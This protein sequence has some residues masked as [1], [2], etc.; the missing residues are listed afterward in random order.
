VPIALTTATYA[1]P[2]GPLSLV[3]GPEGPLAVGFPGRSGRLH[4]QVRVRGAAPDIRVQEGACTRTA[5]AL[6]AYFAGQLKRYR[7]PS[8]L[9][10]WFGL[11]EAQ[12]A[13]T[14]EMC[15][16]PFG[17]TRTYGDIARAT[18]LHPRIVGQMVGAN[19]L[20]ILVPCHRVV[21]ARGA[22]VGYGGGHTRTRGLLAHVVRHG[23]ALV[24]A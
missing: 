13:V 19:Q 17:D 22:L 23:E 20:A 2:I 16:I 9:E 21:G 18:G 15:R 5:A 8:Y 11:S 12:M 10:R 7:F 1:S 24:G 3:E 4:W 14:R 6:D